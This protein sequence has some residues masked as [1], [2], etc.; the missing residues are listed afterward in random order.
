MY[1][2]LKQFL[3]HLYCSS[4]QTKMGILDP[5][6]YSQNHGVLGPSCGKRLKCQWIQ[7]SYFFHYKVL[8]AVYFLLIIILPMSYPM[9]KREI[10]SS[11]IT[12]NLFQLTWHPFIM[13]L[14]KM[15]DVIILLNFLRSHEFKILIFYSNVYQTN[16]QILY[17]M[18][19]YFISE[20]WY[21]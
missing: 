7:I 14:S 15:F 2:L 21:Y 10:V 1:R 18:D 13:E 5:L 9:N 12:L 16:L 4:L 20:K 3:V 17:S 19:R 8:T 6:N 11:Y